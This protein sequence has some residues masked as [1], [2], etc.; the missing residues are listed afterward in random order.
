MATLGQAVFH[1]YFYFSTRNPRCRSAIHA[2]ERDRIM[3]VVN[4]A[5]KR[6]ITNRKAFMFGVAW[7][8]R[9]ENKAYKILARQ[10]KHCRLFR[11]AKGSQTP[12][13]EVKRLFIESI[14]HI[15]K[16]MRCRR[17]ACRLVGR[18]KQY[19]PWLMH[20]RTTRLACAGAYCGSGK[21]QTVQFHCLSDYG[22]DSKNGLLF[23]QSGNCKSHA[24]CE[25]VIPG[26]ICDF[27]DTKFVSYMCYAPP[28]TG[29]LCNAANC[30][31][32]STRVGE[33]KELYR[34][35]FDNMD[36]RELTTNKCAK[37]CG[38]CGIRDQAIHYDCAK[39]TEHC[40]DKFF[41]VW[42]PAQAG[43]SNRK[44]RTHEIKNNKKKKTT[45]G[46]L[47]TATHTDF[48]SPV[49]NRRRCHLVPAGPPRPT[50]GPSPPIFGTHCACALY[51]VCADQE[52]AV[53]TGCKGDWLVAEVVPAVNFTVKGQP[54][55]HTATGERAKSG[56]VREKGKKLCTG[57]EMQNEKKLGKSTPTQLLFTE[58]KDFVEKAG[59]DAITGCQPPLISIL[60]CGWSSAV[61]KNLL[62]WAPRP[63]PQQ[64][65]FMGIGQQ[66]SPRA[67]IDTLRRASSYSMMPS[68]TVWGIFLL[69]RQV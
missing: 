1:Q 2:D 62:W 16:A 34:L 3:D 54:T 11:N 49:G 42:L 66:K 19:L 9:M 64:P 35:C 47:G 27:E 26:S 20:Y 37:T 68:T 30:H 31:D 60:V 6:M 57:V 61:H 67:A 14:R 10:A 29:D 44:H 39:Y 40:S 23:R 69:H 8:L 22:K 65:A 12:E 51:F 5:R 48:F 58:I 33:C 46:K 36:Y 17:R 53:S 7:D 21:S 56:G 45:R 4:Q 13:Q 50:L 15:E 25:R 38:R 43:D 18:S 63:T 28:R 32:A 55:V 24:K 59:E 41:A 52:G